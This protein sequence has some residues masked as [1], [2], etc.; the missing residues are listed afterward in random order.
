MMQLSQLKRKPEH[1]H[2][3]ATAP[4]EVN[5]GKSHQVK[6]VLKTAPA[7]EPLRSVWTE[8]EGM[9]AVLQPVVWMLEDVMERNV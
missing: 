3:P 7:R 1:I 9:H 4:R 6:E 5:Q 2:M 8:R